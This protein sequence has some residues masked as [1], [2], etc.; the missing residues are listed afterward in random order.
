MRARRSW[1]QTNISVFG[2]DVDL[3]ELGQIRCAARGEGGVQESGGSD[4]GKLEESQE[5]LPVFE[6]SPEGDVDDAGMESVDVVSVDVHVGSDWAR[7]S[8][9]KSTSRSLVMINGRNSAERMR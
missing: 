8:R 4:A 9:K 1:E 6:R 3:H 7:G 2:G 5:R